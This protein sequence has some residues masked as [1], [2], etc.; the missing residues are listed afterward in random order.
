MIVIDL[1]FSL[2]VNVSWKP[3]NMSLNDGSRSLPEIHETSQGFGYKQNYGLATQR[4]QIFVEKHQFV[5]IFFLTIW[6]FH[7]MIC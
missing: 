7:Y 3:F 6:F 1:D 4:V 5:L 2:G